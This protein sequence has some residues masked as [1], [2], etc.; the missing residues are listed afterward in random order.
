MNGRVSKPKTR[1]DADL[2]KCQEAF[3][4]SV[5]GI[6]TSEIFEKTSIKE[7][8]TRPFMRPDSRT[9]ADGISLSSLPAFSMTL[10]LSASKATV[11]QAK[12]TNQ[13]AQKI[14]RLFCTRG[15]TTSG[16]F[17]SREAIV[18]LWR[19][20]IPFPFHP[21]KSA[22]SHPRGQ[23]LLS[24]EW[25]GTEL[26]NIGDNVDTGSR[27]VTGTVLVMRSWRTRW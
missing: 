24:T 5:M 23:P 17:L 3:S 18:Y 16:D 2:T 27:R 1:I 22:F 19:I 9:L 10:I 12:Q 7:K 26:G 14:R 11:K 15:P 13:P 25:M 4:L 21:K 6:Q 20:L 8:D